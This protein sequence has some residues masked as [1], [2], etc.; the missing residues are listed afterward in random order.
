MSSHDEYAT[1][2]NP[3]SSRYASDEMLFNFSERKKFTTWRKLWLYL[4]KA[5][6]V[7]QSS[8]KKVSSKIKYPS[9]FQEAGLEITNAQIAELEAC[10]ED[11][12]IRA[13]EEEERKTKHD[14]MAHLHIYASQCP[15]A[16]PIIHLGATSC[17]IGDNTVYS[18][19]KFKSILEIIYYFSF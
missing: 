13:A 2:R 4:A 7:F 17:Y 15:L 9:L 16:S 6:K 8:I 14:V 5:S 1:Y 12:D 3:L 10:V 11:V 18:N 19:F